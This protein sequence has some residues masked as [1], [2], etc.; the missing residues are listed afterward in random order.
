MKV[1]ETPCPKC[2]QPEP[3]LKHRPVVS[4]R[5]PESRVV[6]NSEEHLY[7]QCVRCGYGWHIV[8]KDRRT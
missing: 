5:P 2:E 6:G 8:P 4:P 7:A 1:F 3:T